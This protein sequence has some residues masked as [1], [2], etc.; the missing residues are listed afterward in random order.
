MSISGVVLSQKLTVA[1]QA[2]GFQGKLPGTRKPTTSEIFLSKRR[3]P[4]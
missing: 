3:A 2:V 4:P 1:D